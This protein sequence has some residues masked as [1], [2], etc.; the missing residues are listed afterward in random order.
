M[1]HKSIDQCAAELRPETQHSV[2]ESAKNTQD[3]RGPLLQAHFPEPDNLRRLAG[4]IKQHV[5]ENLDT[6][7]PAVEAQLRSHGVQV[8]WAA[9]AEAANHAVL[10]IMRARNAAVGADA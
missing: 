4:Q 7:L 2:Y 8:H 9:N 3:K 5:I 1:T 6:Y 10:S